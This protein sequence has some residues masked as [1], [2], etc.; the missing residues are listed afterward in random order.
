MPKDSFQHDC[1]HRASPIAGLVGHSWCMVPFLHLSLPS[2]PGKFVQWI[3]Q[4]IVLG[5][6]FHCFP[7]LLVTNYPALSSSQTFQLKQKATVATNCP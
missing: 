5:H 2:E 1:L 7:R 4:Q 3:P 6:H